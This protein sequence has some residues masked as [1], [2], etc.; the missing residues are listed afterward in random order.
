MEFV[1]SQSLV[2]K[3]LRK[4]LSTSNYAIIIPDEH[5]F[6]N[7]NVKEFFNYFYTLFSLKV[8]HYLYGRSIREEGSL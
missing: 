3:R 5:P 1:S 7:I 8:V 2:F 6:A 4:A